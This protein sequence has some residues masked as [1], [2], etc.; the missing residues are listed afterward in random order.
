MCVYPQK[1]VTVLKDHKEHATGTLDVE[2]KQCTLQKDKECRA[3]ADM[4]ITTSSNKATAKCDSTK[5][6]HCSKGKSET[7]VKDEN[8]SVIVIDDEYDESKQVSM[9]EKSSDSSMEI[10]F[11]DLS[12]SRQ[13]STIDSQ[14]MSIR[15]DN[16]SF[17]QYRDSPHSVLK[18]KAAHS[19]LKP[20]IVVRD[21]DESSDDSD[22]EDLGNRKELEKLKISD[23]EAVS[24]ATVSV[25]QDLHLKEQKAE[26]SPVSRSDTCMASKTGLIKEGSP[27]NVCRGELA[28]KKD[29]EEKSIGIASKN[30]ESLVVKPEVTYTREGVRSLICERETLASELHRI[31]VSTCSLPVVV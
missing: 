4:R 6:D 2:G 18:N 24:G 31:Q 22:L 13:A 7:Q 14:D 28:N 29:S 15:F 9:K 16:N 12:K 1:D 19:S 10:S 21:S 8:N 3:E 30:S 11:A 5:I 25:K 27:P 23:K 26:K 20:T 17:R